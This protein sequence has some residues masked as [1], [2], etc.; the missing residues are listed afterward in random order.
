MLKEYQPH[1]IDARKVICAVVSS[2]AAKWFTPMMWAEDDPKEVKE[3]TAKFDRWAQ[4]CTK[5]CTSIKLNPASKIAV[6][7]QDAYIRKYANDLLKLEHGELQTKK[8]IMLLEV[9]NLTQC[10]VVAIT[11][12]KR[13]W[14]W[15]YVSTRKLLEKFFYPFFP[16]VEDEGMELYLKMCKG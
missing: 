13:E 11:R 3:Q 1:I 14:N 16:E 12:D 10:N 2:L 15:L 6:R 8:A 5:L 9:A 7:K 4:A